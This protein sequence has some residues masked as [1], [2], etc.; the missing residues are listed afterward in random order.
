ME[1]VHGIITKIAKNLSEVKDKPL[2]KKQEGLFTGQSADH[3]VKTLLK[4]TKNDSGKA[5][6]KLDFYINR[7]GVKIPEKEMVVLNRAKK[8]LEKKK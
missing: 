8:L 5:L 7:G 1:S 3:I 2:P 6:Q 4:D